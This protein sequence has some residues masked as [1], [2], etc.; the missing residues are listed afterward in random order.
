MTS[1]TTKCLILLC[2]VSG[3][4]ASDS[5]EDQPSAFS[6][7]SET[8]EPRQRGPSWLKWGW[9]FRGRLELP[10]ALEYN[11]DRDG[12]FYVHRIRGWAEIAP[13]SWVRFYVQG[14]DARVIGVDDPD[15]LDSVAH[16]IDVRQAYVDFGRPKSTWQLTIGRQELIFGDERLVGADNY[17]D[18]LGQTFGAL[19]LRYQRPGVRLDGFGAFVLEPDYQHM[20]RPST[21]K[22]L[23]GVNAS[24]DVT[25]YKGS[26]I[27]PYFFWKRHRPGD[28]LRL[29]GNRDVFTYGARTAGSLP[30]QLDYNVEMVLQGGHKAE[31]S[32][33]AWAGHW[34][35]GFRPFHTDFGPRLGAEY[36]FASGDHHRGDGRYTTFD[37][38]YPAGYNKYGMADP[39]AW[40]NLRNISGGADWTLNKHCRLGLGY[41]AFWLA[42]IG[43]NLYTKGDEFL[44]GN[45]HASGDHVGNQGSIM[46]AW[47]LSKSWQF[48]VGYARFFPGSYMTDSAFRRQFSTPYFMLSYRFE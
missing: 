20:I 10:A 34:E 40:R 42:N 27:E 41:R 1:R 31:E 16:P 25:R 39:F 35:L 37:D 19:R 4:A 3:S 14:Q 29:S 45:P 47:E 15:V 21:D 33:Q 6:P 38:L 48:Y 32:I 17:W 22:Q 11:T 9:D 44:I 28:E 8:P 7:S 30:A 43:D 24:L 36:N 23:F 46:A 18:P 5:A 12:L 26:V 2:L 13:A